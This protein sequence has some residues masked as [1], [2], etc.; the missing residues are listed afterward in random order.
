MS[1]AAPRT[2]PQQSPRSPPPSALCAP[3]QLPLRASGLPRRQ[4]SAAFVALWTR[5]WERLF[6]SGLCPFPRPRLWPP[7][8][9][10]GLFCFKRCA[11]R[12]SFSSPPHRPPLQVRTAPWND[13]RSFELLPAV[14]VCTQG[15]L[16]GLGKGRN[17]LVLFVLICVC[18]EGQPNS[19]RAWHP[20]SVA[21]RNRAS[22][23][24]V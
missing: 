8:P 12:R 13:P 3:D 2:C 9:Q 16:W 10:T 15:I 17:C 5:H 14:P 24:E 18:I 19:S 20:Q 22:A 6:P 11:H 4:V 21:G 23:E 1:P 7:L